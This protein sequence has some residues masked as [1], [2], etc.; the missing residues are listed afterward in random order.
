M[1]AQM[2]NPDVI[3][4]VTDMDVARAR[5]ANYRQQI[6][7]ESNELARRLQ[8]APALSQTPGPIGSTPGKGGPKK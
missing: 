7:R 5:L 4:E 1:A 6:R 2:K 8:T 3:E